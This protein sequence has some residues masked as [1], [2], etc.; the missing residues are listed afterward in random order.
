LTLRA[1]STTVRVAE[2]LSVLD[3]TEAQAIALAEELHA[4]VILIDGLAG[5]RVALQSGFT[6]VGTLGILLRAKQLPEIGSLLD[7][8]ELGA[9]FFL[10]PH[11]RRKI[12]RQA[13]ET[14]Q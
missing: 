12:L 13:G 6:V 4:R 10:S 5:R 2:L 3:A 8:L 9:R 11:L 7:R 1:P 14:A